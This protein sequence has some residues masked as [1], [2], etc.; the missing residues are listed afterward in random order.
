[1]KVAPE[2][3]NRNFSWGKGAAQASLSKAAVDWLTQTVDLSLLI[4]KIDANGFGA[5]EE[6]WQML[7]VSDFLGMPGHFTNKCLQQGKNTDFITRMS[8]WKYGGPQECASG[9]NRHVICLLGVEDIPTLAAF[10][11]IMANKMMPDFDIAAIDC[12][13]EVIYNRTHLDQDDHPLERSYYENMVNVKTQR[14]R[15]GC[16]RRNGEWQRR[17]K[18]AENDPLMTISMR[19]FGVGQPSAPCSNS[20]NRLRQSERIG[21]Q[22]LLRRPPSLMEAASAGGGSNSIEFCESNA[23]VCMNGM[24]GSLAGMTGTQDIYENGVVYSRQGESPPLP[25]APNTSGSHYNDAMMQQTSSTGRGGQEAEEDD[26]D[27]EMQ[28]MYAN[29]QGKQAIVPSKSQVLFYLSTS[30][31]LR[32]QQTGSDMQ[33][34]DSSHFPLFDI[35][36]ERICCS[37]SPVWIVESYGRRVMIVTETH[38]PHALSWLL[39]RFSLF[40]SSRRRPP[41]LSVIDWN[42]HPIGLF[43]PGEPLI[44]QNSQRKTIARCNRLS[45]DGECWQWVNEVND[46][47]LARLSHGRLD[48]Y[49]EATLPMPIKLLVL[50]SLTSIVHGLHHSPSLF[51][52]LQ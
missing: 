2:I 45:E 48:F 17:Q 33:I 24:N 30:L 32:V 52:C 5:D 3:L 12:W 38:R 31:H 27:E 16:L 8:Q 50:A 42:G 9:V 13:H 29:G 49:S 14:Q 44:I 15:I 41:S 39:P 4:A 18:Q 7:Q 43:L 21:G 46:I 37:N 51:S 28:S 25:Q 23:M 10:P 1:S 36:A 34:T 26:I 40:R 19:T 20:V 11:N 22:Q 35:W 6:L 47:E